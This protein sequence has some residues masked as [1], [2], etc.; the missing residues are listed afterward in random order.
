M[1]VVEGSDFPELD[2][3]GLNAV[4]KS[5][6]FPMIP[7]KIPFDSVSIN[8][9]FALDKVAVY[10]INSPNLTEKEK[11]TIEEDNKKAEE[12]IKQYHENIAS[13]INKLWDPPQDK[14]FALMANL[15][16]VE[17]YVLSSGELYRPNI[18]TSSGDWDLDQS[19]IHTLE[20]VAPFPPLPSEIKTDRF[21]FIHR[22][23]FK[24]NY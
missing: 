23:L 13:K 5:A 4:K 2:E 22:F 24:Q 12:A 8:Y 6:P 18:T 1:K 3:S 15:V 20:L 7:E 19:A 10:D 11:T 14:Y 21:K 16:E 9:T 17:F